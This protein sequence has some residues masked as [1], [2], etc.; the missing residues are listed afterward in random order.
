MDSPSARQPGDFNWASTL[1]HEMSHVYILTA[2]NHRV[3]AGSPKALRSTK[4]RKRRPSGAIRITPD[5]VVAIR[6]KK[7]LPVARS[8]SRLHP[9]RVSLAGDRFLLSGGPHLRLH[10]E[11]LGRRQAARH[12]PLLRRAQNHARGDSGESRH[13]A[14]GI[15]QAISGLAVQGRSAD[16]RRFRQV[17]RSTERFGAS[18]EGRQLRRGAKGRRRGRRRYIRNTSTAPT[19]TNSSPKP[20]WRKATSQPRL[21]SLRNTKSKA[22][23]IRTR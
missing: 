7:L 15:R 16:R 6:D 12:G 2:T 21:P 1:W 20:I 11:P 4:K 13:D 17:A 9:S 8:R 5:I 23:A 10:P 3:P 19:P 14:G 22:A 18:R